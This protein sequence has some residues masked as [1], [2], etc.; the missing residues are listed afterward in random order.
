MPK[1]FVTHDLEKID[2]S[3]AKKFGEIETVIRGPIKSADLSKTLATMKK[4]LDGLGA[5][6]YVLAAGHP[7][8]IAFAG[9][10]QYAKHGVIRVLHWDRRRE[11]YSLA[12]VKA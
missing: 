9:A 7:A 12:E 6:D 10:L 4:R 8:L 11:L 3:T 5:D 1:V 2:F